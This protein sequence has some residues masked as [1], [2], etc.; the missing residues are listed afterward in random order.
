MECIEKI[1]SEYLDS[2]NDFVVIHLKEDCM[3]I[4]IIEDLNFK[5]L[6]FEFSYTLEELGL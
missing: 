6:E 4:P 2:D 1:G 5:R 3:S